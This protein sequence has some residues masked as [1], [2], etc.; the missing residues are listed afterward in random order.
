MKLLFRLLILLIC[1][2]S[3]SASPEDAVRWKIETGKSI[4]ASPAVRG[5]MLYF[6]STDHFFYAVNRITGEISWQFDAGNPVRSNAV[7]SDPGICF[8]SG[9]QVFMLDFNGILKWQFTMDSGTASDQYDS[10]DYF[11][12]SPVI[13]DETVFTGSGSGQVYGL[14]IQTGTLVFHCTAGTGWGIRAAPV[15][16]NQTLLFGDW[17]GVFYAFSLTDGTLIWSHDTKKDYSHVWQNAIQ[18]PPVIHNGILYFSGRCSNL[19]AMNP[20]NGRLIWSWHSP[21]DQWIEGGPVID[22]DVLYIGSSDQH[23]FYGFSL[24]TGEPIFVR[25]LDFRIFGGAAL[26]EENAYAGSGSLYAVNKNTGEITGRLPMLRDIVSRPVLHEGML[27]FGSTDGIFYAVD[28]NALTNTA[29]PETVSSAA[30]TTDLGTLSG[31]AHPRVSLPLKNPGAGADSITV[32]LSGA[33]RLRKAWTLNRES[34]CLEPGDSTAVILELDP[35]SLKYQDY[36]LS[37]TIHSAYNLENNDIRKWIRMTLTEPSGVHDRSGI[38]GS[39]R[40]QGNYP[41]PFNPDTR[42]I[43]NLPDAARVQLTI[44]DNLGRE[45][46]CADLGMQN[47][48]NHKIRFDGKSLPS[49]NYV[50]LLKAGSLCARHKMILIK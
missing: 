15:I 45:I 16:Y 46:S 6:G 49:G 48:G 35:E 1:I 27:Y 9:D 25:E 3:L 13:A 31:D 30:D 17:D 4:V 32:T 12:S 11:H 7:I 39:F 22:G 40:I 8:E 42:L 33:A 34:F 43:Y 50:V 44:F 5:E 41:N 24:E 14:D 36:T 29:Y 19:Y 38:P 18:T 37:I 23:L 10:W 47:A 20:E 28:E 21:T 26:G 2:R